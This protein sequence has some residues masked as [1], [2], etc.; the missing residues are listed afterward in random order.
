MSVKNVTTSPTAARKWVTD[1]LAE[2]TDEQWNYLFS[3]NRDTKVVMMGTKPNSDGIEYAK[4]N[5]TNIAEMKFARDERGN[6]YIIGY[7]VNADGSRGDMENINVD[8]EE[9]LDVA[10]LRMA[11]KIGMGQ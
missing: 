6:F 4:N 2:F 7:K 8:Q 10:A 3:L 1:E 5:E 11:R 9:D